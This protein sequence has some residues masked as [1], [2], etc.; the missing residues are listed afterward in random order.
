MKRKIKTVSL[1]IISILLVCGI[2]AIVD[3]NRALSGHKPLF[4]I[5]ESGLQA[6]ETKIDGKK[7]LENGAELYQGL[8]YQILVCNGE[9]NTLMSLNGITCQKEVNF[10]PFKVF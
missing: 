7:D 9:F 10:A 2:F 5:T 1:V 3:Y 8:G 6:F 4:M